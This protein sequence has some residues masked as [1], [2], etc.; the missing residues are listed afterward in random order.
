MAKSDTGEKYIKCHTKQQGE[1]S[2]QT[3]IKTEGKANVYAEPFVLL[4]R[5]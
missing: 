3:K 1:R 5:G 4:L 2:Y